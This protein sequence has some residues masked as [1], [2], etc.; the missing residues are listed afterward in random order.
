MYSAE[1]KKIVAVKVYTAM[2]LVPRF[3]RISTICEV[4]SRVYKVE[5]QMIP[6][7]FYFRKRKRLYAVHSRLNGDN[8]RLLLHGCF[9]SI[10]S[11]AQGFTDDR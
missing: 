6:I 9:G 8:G 10:C 4:I 1:E 11:E 3:G 7:A 5:K 2:L